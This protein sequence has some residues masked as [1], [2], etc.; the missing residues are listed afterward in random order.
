MADAGTLKE[1][2]MQLIR[3]HL[4]NGK[5]LSKTALAAATGL[6]FPTV[7]RTVDALV[8]NGELQECGT[9]PSSG[10]RAAKVY[11]LEPSYYMRLLLRLEGKY[12]Y[13]TLC[14]RLGAC[15]EHGET[16]CSSAYLENIAA[17]IQR[18]QV[19][20]PRLCAVALGV[21]ANVHQGVVRET[22]R[23]PELRG[24]NLATE[25]YNK[26]GIPIALETDVLAASLGYWTEHQ[27][28]NIEAVTCIYIGEVGIGS[29]TIIRGEPL[30]GRDGFAGEVHYLP[31]HSKILSQAPD[32]VSEMDIAAYY[33]RLLQCIVVL[34]NP[35]RIV[36]Y[37]NVWLSDKTDRIQMMLEQNVP[38][39]VVPEIIISNQYAKD[40]EKGLLELARKLTQKGKEYEI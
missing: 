27:K 37:Q 6:S 28:E 2:N 3:R 12:L 4:E 14:D 35:E 34:L 18:V 1:I 20:Y 21:A 29:S 8:N 36:L 17:L 13:W 23:Y 33:A 39:H 19:R 40:Y 9:Q 11:A 5:S 22:F 7:S 25:L 31:I 15:I 32:E 10:G 26:C 30:R 16:V 38:K 24:V